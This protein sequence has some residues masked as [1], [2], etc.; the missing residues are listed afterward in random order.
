M[1]LLVSFDENYLPQLRVLL[2][3]LY[4][5]DPGVRCRVHLLHR[6]ISQGQ[7][8]QLREDVEKLGWELCP[9]TVDGRLFANAPATKQYPKRCI[10]GCWQGSCF[11]RR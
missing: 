2:V 8:D 1:D 10:T 4:Q 6:A 5:N 9:V 7:I 11:P 3:S